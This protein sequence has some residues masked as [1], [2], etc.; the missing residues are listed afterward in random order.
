[1]VKELPSISGHRLF[2][3]G[4]LLVY[5][6]HETFSLDDAKASTVVYSQVIAEDGY[7]LLLLDFREGGGADAEV[8]RHLAHWGKDNADRLCIAAVGG[9]FVLRTTL[10]LVLT[11]AKVLGGQQPTVQFFGS[12]DDARAWLA[13]QG[14][15]LA[16]ALRQSQASKP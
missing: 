9:N 16:A 10:T 11:A 2:R 8:R 7:L 14:A 15:N 12:E 6:Q 3:D 1:M 4:P 5:R 13:A